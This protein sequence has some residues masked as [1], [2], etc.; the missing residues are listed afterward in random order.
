MFKIG[1]RQKLLNEFEAV[2]FSQEF[3]HIIST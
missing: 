3:K 1:E 2:K